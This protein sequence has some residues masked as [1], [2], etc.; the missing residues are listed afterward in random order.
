MVEVNEAPA[1]VPAPAASPSG[2][3]KNNAA[4]IIIIVVGVL[5]VL[6]VGGYFISRYIARKASEKVTEGILGAATGGKVDVNS[7]NGSVSVSNDSGTTEIGAAKWP[8]DM[9]SDIPELKT[10]KITFATS[11]KTN[12]SYSVSSS[13]VTKAEF[14]TYKSSVEAAG[15]T[16]TSTASFGTDVLEYEKGTYNLSLVYDESSGGLSITATPKS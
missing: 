12:K 6:G 13:E 2:G 9:P 14:E 5:L 4:V 15:W 16:N 11:D 1:P 8:T 10:G 3:K 7:N